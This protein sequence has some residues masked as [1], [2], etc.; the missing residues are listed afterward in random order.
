MPQ[1]TNNNPETIT[2]EFANGLKDIPNL[3]IKSLLRSASD[4]DLK[5]AIESYSAV[6]SK[7]FDEISKS[8]VAN[9]KNASKQE[10]K[11]ISELI[12]KSAGSEMIKSVGSFSKNLRSIFSRLSLNSIVKEIKKLILFIL[13]RLNVKD[14]IIE[15]LLI[16]D[17]ILNALL[18]LDLPTELPEVLSKMEVNYLDEI[19]AYYGLKSN[20]D[21]SLSETE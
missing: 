5:H 16:I 19:K 9:F 18:G 20:R 15:V 1:E 13:D 4:E 2:I 10:Q 17:Q 21:F 7:Q 12:T 14:W 3:I 11:D 8:I 6:F